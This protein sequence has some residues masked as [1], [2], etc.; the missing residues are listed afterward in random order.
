[1]RGTVLQREQTKDRTQLEG[2]LWLPGENRACAK[3]QKVKRNQLGKGRLRKAGRAFQAEATA[4]AEAVGV[5]KPV[6][7]ERN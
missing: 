2:Q 5:G 4:R 3:I 1:M 6:A 7:Q